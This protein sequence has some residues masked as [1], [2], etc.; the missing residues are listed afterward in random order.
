MPHTTRIRIRGYHLD[1][2]GHVNNARYLELLEEAR[3]SLLED[4]VA[5]DDWIARGFVFVVVRVEIDYRR[6][7]TVG[8]T[9]VIESSVVRIGGSSA[10][11]RQVCR[12]G[13]GGEVAAE[14]HVTFA[15]LDRETGRPR[16]ME[17]EL[18]AGF[19]AMTAEGEA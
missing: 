9:L 15:V 1:L 7:V 12:R 6:P 5:L 3:W 4:H 17:G 13:E 11:I 8:H 18:L 2:Y 14:A 10:V 19:R 16:R